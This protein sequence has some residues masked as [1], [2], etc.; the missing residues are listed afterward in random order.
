VA[1][2]GEVAVAILG[3]AEKT[4]SAPATESTT[5]FIGHLK[6]GLWLDQLMIGKKNARTQT[7][8]SDCFCLT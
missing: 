2:G 1:L 8:V 4:S 7:G 3:S 6:H 5:F